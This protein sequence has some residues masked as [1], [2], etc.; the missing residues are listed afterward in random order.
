MKAVKKLVAG[1]G[2]TVALGLGATAA[3]ASEGGCGTYKTVD[4]K[5]AHLACEKAPVDLTNKAS[6]QRGASLFMSYCA[7]CHSAQYVRYSKMYKDLDIPKELVE[8]YLMLTTDQVGDHINAGVDPELQKAW[9]GAQPPDLSLETRLRGNDWVYTYL[10]AFYEDPSRPWGAN[11]IVLPNAAMPFVLHDMQMNTSKEEYRRNIGDI[12]NFM[13]W[14]AEPQAHQRKVYGF[15]VILFLLALLIPVYLLNKEFWKD[16]RVPG[17]NDEMNPELEKAFRV[18][19]FLELG[20]LMAKDAL[21]REESCGGHFRWDHATP[22]GEAERDD[23]NFKFVS[24]WEYN[25]E[26]INAEILHKEDLVYEN[27]E[28]KTRSYK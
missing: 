24:C 13:A 10:L 12:V 3:Q 22:E 20:Q 27:I 5:D 14:M 2:L 19:D 9:F 28:V 6:I 21:T 4:G 15:W 16:V 23:A 17:S 7:G 18:A 1:L 8:K 25:G 11:N 26:D